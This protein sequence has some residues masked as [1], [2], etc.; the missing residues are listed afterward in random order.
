MILKRAFASLAAAVVIGAFA[1][2]TQPVAAGGVK[3]GTLACNVSGG[4]GLII[5]S[6]KTMRC[7][8]HRSDGGV[9]YYNG[10]IRKFGLDIGVTKKAHMAW[11]VLAPGSTASG[12]LA[13]TY[14]GAAAEATIG[15]GVGANVLVGGFNRSITLQPVSAQVQTGINVAAGVA[16][17]S[18]Q[19]AR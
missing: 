8:F 14:G 7:A 19:A 2:G 9:E 17:L 16:S 10:S 15:G 4:F 13:G 5:T 18:L 6:K 1:L 3:V 11:V 12:A